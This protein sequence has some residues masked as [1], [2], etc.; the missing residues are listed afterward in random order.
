MKRIISNISVFALLSFSQLSAQTIINAT[1]PDNL[2]EMVFMSGTSQVPPINTGV[3][4]S[5]NLVSN[6]GSIMLTSYVVSVWDQPTG[7]SKIH[8][9]ASQSFPAGDLTIPMA[10]DPDVEFDPLLGIGAYVGYMNANEVYIS[11][12]DA[13]I[14]PSTGLVLGAVMPFPTNDVIKSVNIDVSNTSHTP[15]TLGFGVITWDENG[16]IYASSFYLTSALPLTFQISPPAFVGTGSQPD[17][18][19]S[20]EGRILEV[21][22]IDDTTGDLIIKS[23]DIGSLMAGNF[24]G[25]VIIESPASGIISYAEPRIARSHYNTAEYKEE[26]TVVAMEVGS[27]SSKIVA[28]THNNSGFFNYEVSVGAGNTLNL[29][30]VVCYN[31]EKIKFAWASEY[32]LG[33]STE[34]WELTD[35][36]SVGEDILLAEFDRASLSLVEMFEVN[37]VQGDFHRGNPSIAEARWDDAYNLNA[38]VYN[39]R[40]NVGSSSYYTIYNKKLL[41]SANPKRMAIQTEESMVLSLSDE[42]YYLTGDDLSDYDFE[43]Y[44]LEGKRMNISSNMELTEQ[45]LIINTNGLSSGMYVLNCNSQKN[46]KTFKLMV[47]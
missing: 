36:R 2:L 44:N 21:V 45:E 3:T 19:I 27:F 1:N 24:T 20:G 12:Y 42:V 29:K 47:K 35:Y 25:Y 41:A 13:T 5:N 33:S 4:V 46:I 40:V 6:P 10:S 30:P 32:G 37:K 26:Y 9:T 7:D 31:H 39:N 28:F 38:F 14:S 18:S 23:T 43:I 15:G 34:L 8:W 11:W 16:S 17:I 22:Y